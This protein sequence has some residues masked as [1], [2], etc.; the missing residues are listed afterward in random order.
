[1]VLMVQLVP[2]IRVLRKADSKKRNSW[3]DMKAYG[4]DPALMPHMRVHFG[5]PG[6]KMGYR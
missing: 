2:G 4:V 1:M 3:L 5:T 6:S